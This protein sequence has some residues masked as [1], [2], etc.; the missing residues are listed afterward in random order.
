MKID[1]WYQLGLFSPEDQL[2]AIEQHTTNVW[3]SQRLF[4]ERTL[5]I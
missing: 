1:R 2:L 5:S 4:H 3:G